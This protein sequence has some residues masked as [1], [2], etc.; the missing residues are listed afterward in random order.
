MTLLGGAAR[1]FHDPV[2]AIT[3]VLGIELTIY[4]IYAGRI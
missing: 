1:F 4:P 2:V 3:L